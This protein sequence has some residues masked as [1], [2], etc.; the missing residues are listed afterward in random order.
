M[1]P[2][3]CTDWEDEADD[4]ELVVELE[5][6][7]AEEDDDEAEVEIEDAPDTEEVAPVDELWEV[8]AELD[9][10]TLVWVGVLVEVL[11]PFPNEM[12]A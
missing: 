6:A 4:E 1:R 2:G 8:E 7:E 5:V 10:I 9:V 3:F 12:A 11:V